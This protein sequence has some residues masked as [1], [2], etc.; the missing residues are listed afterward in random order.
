NESQD[1]GASA[2][3]GQLG[4]ESSE[5]RILARGFAAA[6]ESPYEGESIRDFQLIHREILFSKVRQLSDDELSKNADHASLRML[7]KQQQGTRARLLSRLADLRISE[8]TE[9]LEHLAD[10]A[11]QSCE[12]L[13]AVEALARAAERHAAADQRRCG[14]WRRRTTDL[15]EQHRMD[16]GKYLAR[17]LAMTELTSR[18]AEIV[19]LARRGLNNAQ[20]ARN[21]ILSQRTVEGHLY[22]VFSKLGI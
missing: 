20:I 18:E 11:L 2:L 19:N 22:R 9:A 15:I 13:V 8:G 10:E 4:E 16:P 7:A 6:L 14:A 3:S 21:L 17:V 5:Y 12:N 1:K